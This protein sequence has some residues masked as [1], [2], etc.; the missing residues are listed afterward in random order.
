MKKILLTLGLLSIT[1]LF[2][3]DG[4]SIYGKC[5]SCHGASGEKANFAKLQGLSKDDI[6]AKL[7]GY[8]N[9]QGGAKKAMMIPQVKS[10]S[11]EDIDAVATYISKF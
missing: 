5:A 4:A 9:G 7:T 6:V 2:A 10:L 11:A 3:A 8:Q 1:S